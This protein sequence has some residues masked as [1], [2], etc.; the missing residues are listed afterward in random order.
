M[1]PP[2]LVL[3][4]VTVPQIFLGIPVARDIQDAGDPGMSAQGVQ[5]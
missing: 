2:C 5:V 3:A 4:F 1:V